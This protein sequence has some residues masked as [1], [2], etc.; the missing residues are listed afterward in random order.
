MR[1]NIGW[2]DIHEV[3]EACSNLAFRLLEELGHN[4]FEIVHE[5]NYDENTF[6]VKIIIIHRDNYY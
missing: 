4:D 1:P 3:A 5:E 2:E 6:E